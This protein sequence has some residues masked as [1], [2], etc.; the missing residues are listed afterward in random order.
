MDFKALAFDLSLV[1]KDTWSIFRYRKFMAL[2]GNM[3]KQITLG[4][5]IVPIV[6]FE[7]YLYRKTDYFMPTLSF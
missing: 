1:D 2:E 3:W 7:S 6:E 4:E 5:R